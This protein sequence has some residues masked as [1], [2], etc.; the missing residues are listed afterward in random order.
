MM[1]ELEAQ[2]Q[3]QVSAEMA[4]L[5]KDLDVLSDQ[6]GHLAT[7]LNSVLREPEVKE[8]T[9]VG[10]PAPPRCALAHHLSEMSNSI[11]SY[12]RNIND[13]IDRLEL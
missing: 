9:T 6:I 10:A 12:I 11:H 2:K 1:N 5:D 4:K 8:D 3:T 7:R 13:L